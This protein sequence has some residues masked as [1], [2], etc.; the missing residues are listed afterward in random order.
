[1]WQGE[2]GFCLRSTSNHE[3][4]TSR[5]AYLNSPAGK[6]LSRTSFFQSTTLRNFIW[7]PLV[8]ACAQRDRAEVLGS[9]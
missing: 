9:R 4:A 8:F 3:L 6:S 2:W 1:M 5:T 7:T